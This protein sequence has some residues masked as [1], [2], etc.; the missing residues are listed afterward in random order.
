MIIQSAGHIVLCFMCF[1]VVCSE[2]YD[3]LACDGLTTSLFVPVCAF[4]WLTFRQPRLWTFPH[5]LRNVPHN[6]IHNFRIGNKSS[7]MSFALF[8]SGNANRRRTAR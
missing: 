1:F 3:D 2:E 4:L 7:G 5:S 8:A 6:H